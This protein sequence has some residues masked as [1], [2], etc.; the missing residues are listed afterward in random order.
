MCKLHSYFSPA[1]LAAGLLLPVSAAIQAQAY[2][3]VGQGEPG[4]R[5]S[6]ITNPKM[7]SLGRENP[8]ATFTSFPNEELALKG[9]RAGASTRMSLNGEWK[10]KYVDNFPDRPTDFMKP[11]LD[12]SGWDNIKVPGNWERQG[13]GVPI[14]S[15]SGWAFV[16]QGYDKYLQEPNPPYV[17]EEWNPTGTYRR[18][19]TL[20]EEWQGKEIFISFDGTKGCAFYYL[21]G[22][23]LGMSKDAKT[24]SRFLVTEKVKP[25]E[26][27][28]AVQV[29]RFSDANYL[30]C[31]DFWRLSGFE[32]EVYLYAQPKER[33][34]DFSA[35]ATLDENYD[36]GILELTA[37]TKDVQSTGGEV[38]A[39][40][41]DGQGN[42]VESA[43]LA[44][45]TA[46]DGGKGE[47]WNVRFEG[48]F[49]HWTAETPNLYTLVISVKDKSG[50]VTEA[51]SCK[52]GF[53]TAEVKDGQFLVNGKPILVKGVNMHEHNEYTG[54]Y[55]D[56]ELMLKDISLFKQL[57]VNTVRCCHYPQ[58]ERFYELCDEYG[59]YVIDEVNIESHGMG[60]D[61]RIG[62]TL[63]NNLE[64]FDA[65]MARTVNMYERDK[66]HACI[67]TWSLGNEAGNGYNFYQTYL[68]MKEKDAS[69]PV[70]YEQA[71]HEWNSDIYCP[72]YPRPWDI[73]RYAQ[74]EYKK[75]KRPLIMC[76]YAHAMGNSLGG[77][78]Y[79]WQIIKKYPAL[80]GGCI[81]DWVDQGMAE[82]TDD[83]RKY[84]AY[85]GDFGD[86]GT[87][88]D[89]TFCINGIVFP[90]R[91]LKP[92][93]KEMAKVY[94]N[95][96]FIDFDSVAKTVRIANG[97]FFTDLEKY[98]F[99]YQIKQNGKL[100][101][102][103]KLDVKCAPTDTVEVSLKGFP[104]QASGDTYVYFYVKQRTTEPFL[105]AGHIVAREQK[106]VY[107]APYET[108]TL[109]SSLQPKED[110]NTVSYQGKNFSVSFDKTS[111]LMTSYV[112]GG[113]QFILDGKGPKPDFWRAPVENDYGNNAP[114]RLRAWREASDAEAKV[115]SFA[116]DGNKVTVAYR[117]EEVGAQWKAV[118]TI[119]DD[120]KIHVEN[121]FSSQA[122]GQTVEGDRGRRRPQGTGWIPRVGL[123]MQMPV[124]YDNL[125]YY[126]CGP[127]EN[128]VDRRAST[129]VD[130]Y[131]AKV[132]DMYVPYI[133][134]EENEHRTN[135]RWLALSGKGKGLLIVADDRIEF[136]ASNYPR[137]EFDCGEDIRNGS[138][139][140][141]G[142]QKKHNSDPRKGQL[143]D[144]FID[145][146]MTGVG[147]DNSWGAEPHEWDQ[148]K[149][150]KEYSYS[151]TFVPYTKNFKSL[152]KKY[153]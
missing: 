2:I 93:S 118:Y 151:F 20:P 9:D 144:L 136:N 68:W 87:P 86:E 53:R 34:V 123:R 10:F 149:Q 153:Q 97:F 142:Q 41:Y 81:W 103:G 55:V 46:S 36:R 139:V 130:E 3:P 88:S 126:G 7:T 74:N 101:Y 17:P 16:S 25:G 131:E 79:Y 91:T 40:L 6:I 23:F 92:Q 52:V 14:Y 72:M 95:V 150:G 113:Q 138:P 26:N 1:L 128:Y 111:G 4:E 110:G 39:T 59:I 64:F 96:D 107:S 61:R 147:G 11:D 112:F 135:V 66:N 45:S 133:R 48:A 148:M 43:E 76:E 67:I 108:E 109:S 75:E 50:N 114:R 28:L 104:S 32:R 120:G 90:D 83:G 78:D 106:L 82:T 80:Q 63:A 134:P 85:G 15:N 132:S 102:T 19:F 27:V 100:V 84:W 29:H 71:Y 35:L 146:G 121:T 69:R 37:W 127:Y 62:G 89:G 5:Y 13:F 145:C 141:E 47:S 137:E 70:Q 21:N 143:V 105:P 56:E 124:A 94:Q 99:S 129:F 115:E 33:L 77:F 122:A 18:T 60:Y 22:Q 98:D 152:V 12:D 49:K 30:E 54:H 65:H 24:P 57:N 117:Y 125:T 116:V 38:A 51:T 73:E 8:R 140:Y 42:V 58:Q 119:A 31:Q 44:A